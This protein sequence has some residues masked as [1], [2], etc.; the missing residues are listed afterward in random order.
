MSCWA[1]GIPKW[2]HEVYFVACKYRTMGYHVIHDVLEKGTYGEICKFRRRK[3]PF[4]GVREG[5]PDKVTRT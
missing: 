1:V 5:S 2:C 4:L 3:S